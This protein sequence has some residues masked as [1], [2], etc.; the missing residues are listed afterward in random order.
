MKPTLR[1]DGRWM[2]QVRISPGPKGRTPIYGHS[3]EQCLRNAQDHLAG[4][5]LAATLRRF[6]SGSLAAFVYGTFTRHIY[7]D[8]RQTSRRRHDVNLRLHIL[9]AL[10]HLQLAEITV[11]DVLGLKESLVRQDKRKG[12]LSAKSRREV[13]LLLRSIFNLAMRLDA[14]A[15]SPAHKVSLPTVP[16][17]KARTEPE[18]DFTERLF[19][20][21]HGHWMRGPLFAALFLG[22]RRG[23]VCGLK[24]SAIDRK[25]LVL[26]V[27]EQRHP[28]LPDGST[29]KTDKP[30]S[31]P[32]TKSLLDHLDALGDPGSIYVFTDGGKPILPNEVSKQVPRLC[33]K[34]GLEKRTFH[35]LRSFAASNLGALGVDPITIMEILGHT[36]LST[37]LKYLD[38][39]T[40]QKRQALA[41]LLSGRLPGAG[42]TTGSD[43]K[44]AQN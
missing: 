24:W 1:K 20:Q 6:E 40:A 38:G 17:K 30:R 5:A 4:K 39:K 10:G 14:V 9:P 43:N 32:I 3:E 35:D 22:L 27:V 19:A 21:A 15:K 18:A 44:Q 37:T 26:H 41:K 13:L 31:L 29:P 7:P 42:L 36:E 23:E 12:D 28:D 16:S 8:I 25:K 33:A 2:V 11:E 34:G